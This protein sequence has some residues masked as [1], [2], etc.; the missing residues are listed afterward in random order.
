MRFAN[1]KAGFGDMISRRGI[2]TGGGATLV[3]GEVALS[4]EP[5]LDPVTCSAISG[6]I[7]FLIA[8]YGCGGLALISDSIGYAIAPWEHI[9]DLR[10]RNM[11]YP[12]ARPRA[13]FRET[14]PL[15]AAL[16]PQKWLLWTGANLVG[17]PSLL[18][19]DVEWVCCE[20]DQRREIRLLKTFSQRGAVLAV[21]PWEGHPLSPFRENPSLL[22]AGI[23]SVNDVLRSAAEAE[24]VP[25]I[26]ST[27]D[28]FMNPLTGLA[29]PGTT[30]DLVHLSSTS[31]EQ[32]RPMLDALVRGL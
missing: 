27:C 26:E 32:L 4:Y 28:M 5:E 19:N 20:E 2:L 7:R 3:S 1:L 31:C 15:L 29:K 6:L 18:K 24:G 13:I 11:S 30:R 9:G 22:A 8:T 14:M 16:R 21:C 25:F 10:Q 23:R 17:F 12:G